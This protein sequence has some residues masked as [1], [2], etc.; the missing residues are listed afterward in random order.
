MGIANLQKLFAPD[1]IAVIGASERPGSIGAA[2]INNLL[3][4]GFTGRL[5]PVNPKYTMVR[6]WRL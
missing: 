3:D 6:G 1:S 2:L 5:L 4:G